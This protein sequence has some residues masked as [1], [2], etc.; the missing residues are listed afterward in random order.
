MPSIT[1]EPKEFV[2]E[3]H[4]RMPVILPE[5]RHEAWL[6]GKAGK[7]VLV[8]FLADRMKTS[9]VSSRVTVR[10]ATTPK[11]SC[12]SNFNLWRQRKTSRSCFD[13]RLVKCASPFSPKV[14]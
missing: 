2:R 9:P 10:K 11:S 3:I 13:A 7:E 12:R 1:G 14:P 5:E 4:T 8:P 6:S